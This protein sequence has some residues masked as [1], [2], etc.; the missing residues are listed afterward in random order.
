MTKY[1][2][3]LLAVYSI[4]FA[5]SSKSDTLYMELPNVVFFY[6]SDDEIDSLESNQEEISEVLSDYFYYRDNV[7]EYLNEIGVPST[8]S[9]CDH[10]VLKTDTANV[11]LLNRHDIDGL[12]GYILIN[13]DASYRVSVGVNTDISIMESIKEFFNIE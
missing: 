4:G 12:V 3:I 10:F 9:S 8:F 1:V 2:I 11:H 7:V 5:Q 6:P 13:N